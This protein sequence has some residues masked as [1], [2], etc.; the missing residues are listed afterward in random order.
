MES[1]KSPLARPRV[2]PATG[3]NTAVA[4]GTTSFTLPNGLR[5]LVHED[6][7]APVVAL[8]AWVQV[9]AAD[10]HDREAGVAHVHEHMLFKGTAR[11]GVGQIAAEVESAGGQINAFT[12]PDHTVYHLVLAERHFGTGLDI[13]SDALRN[14]TFDPDELARELKVVLEEWKRSED[15]PVSRGYAELF[16]KTFQRHPYGRPV[17]GWR[18]TIESFDQAMVLDFFRRWYLPNNTVLVIVGDVRVA[19]AR[20]LVAKTFGPWKRGVIRRRTRPT[21][22][23]ATRPRFAAIDMRVQEH[24]LILGFP[25]P[26]AAATD[27][28]ALDLLSYILAGGESTR[29]VQSLEAEKELANSISAFAYT[30]PDP[31]VFVVLA[32]LERRKIKRAAREIMAELARMR[33][34]LVSPADLARA[35]GNLESEFVY[36]KESVQGRA[37]LLG[38]SQC[39]FDDA[40]YE[41]RYLAALAGATREDIQRV[42]R[43]YL[44]PARLLGILVG[45]DAKRLVPKAELTAPRRA[46]NGRPARD[47]RP[48]RA[49]R[50][51]PRAS[52]SDIHTHQLANGVRL[53]VKEHP[54][55][56][57]LALRAA[58]LG[59]LLFERSTNAG[60]NN[61]LAGMMS[62]GTQYHSRA[63]LGRSI[64]SLAGYLDAFSGRNS[65]GIRGQFLS[66]HVE[67]ASDLFLEMLRTPTLP[68]DEI[69]KRRREV[70]IQ[71]AQRDDE[72]AQRAIELF[73]ETHFPRHPYGMAML[74]TR[75]TVQRFTRPQ[76]LAYHRRLLAPERLVVSAVGD[77]DASWLL[78]RLETGLGDLG[79]VAPLPLPA[80][81]ARL[82]STRRVAR[83]LDRKQSHFI[84]GVRGCRIAD[85]G[86]IALKMIEAVLS[87]QG[88]RLFLELRD[89]QGLAYSVSAFASEGVAPGVFGVY[90]ACSPDV[91]EHAIQ[92]VLIELQ[93]LRDDL[94][95][96]DEL[97]DAR[98]Y[99]LGSYD[100][101]LQTDAAQAD[102]LL[103]NEVYGLGLDGGARYREA[104]ASITPLDVRA[105]ARKYLTL[106][107]YTLAVV[108]PSTRPRGARQ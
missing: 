4:D 84:L 28:V 98:R 47:P 97:N 12:T 71:V 14:S 1:R 69:E 63:M 65:F 78:H 37:R 24:Q 13:L 42:A 95:G 33:D 18:K 49:P 68:P 8:Q 56:P 40:A 30:P 3:A 75:Q 70:L 100:I 15:M 34:Q 80:P 31:G 105:A 51:R 38:Y 99:L 11:R 41:H 74:G 26:G 85:P 20:R 22:P 54:G 29:L 67:E 55:A 5:V 25:I 101:S 107:A 36:R 108:G 102:E 35:R 27:T 61:F 77:V 6:R 94:V 43:T 17:I 7:F 79:R 21:E 52:A 50:T 2:V 57:L 81:A 82:T 46:P 92:G 90:F 44:D 88:G 87:R 104:L 32:S 9:G 62:R 64:E 86:R 76:L 23:A 72:P 93:R 48:A 58:T 59:G 19:D 39:V 73:Y 45:P 103:F 53:I 96:Q 60:I 89:R 16:R 66:R 10:E 106:D 91:L 83:K